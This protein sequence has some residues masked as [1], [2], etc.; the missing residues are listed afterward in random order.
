[1]LGPLWV[2]LALGE[3][4]GVAS[5]IGGALILAALLVRAVLERTSPSVLRNPV[6]KSAPG[7]L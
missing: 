3:N 4:P 1:V 5:L 2:W 6:V 7:T